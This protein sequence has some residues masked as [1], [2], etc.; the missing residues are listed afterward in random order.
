VFSTPLISRW[1]GD[2]LRASCRAG[3]AVP[4][5]RRGPKKKNPV[6]TTIAASIGS[7]TRGD[8]IIAPIFFEGVT[9]RAAPIASKYFLIMYS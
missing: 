2:V 3:C 6:E 1:R 8:A 4:S 7:D 5:E 9:Q